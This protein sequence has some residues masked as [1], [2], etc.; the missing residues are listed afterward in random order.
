MPAPWKGA[1]VYLWRVCP[2]EQQ[3]QADETL[4][5]AAAAEARRQAEADQLLGDTGMRKIAHLTLDRFD[6]SALGGDEADHPYTVATAWLAACLAHGP[7]G[8]YRD[9]AAP[10][11]ALYFYCPGFG[12]GKTHLA[13]GLL[14]HARQAGKLTAFIEETSYIDRSWSCDLEDKEALSQLPGERAWLTVVDDLGRRTI[15]KSAAGVQNAWAAVFTRRWLT[16]GWTIITS[17]HT[18]DQLVERQTIDD[19][20]YS[21]IKQMTRGEYVVFDGVD[22]RLEGL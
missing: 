16:C 21:R 10:A 5:I 15:G 1:T 9:P 7:V 3:R 14:W 13:A 2:C 17:N 8:D 4:R 22:I 6:P 20:I 18:L 19:A 11:T 12:R